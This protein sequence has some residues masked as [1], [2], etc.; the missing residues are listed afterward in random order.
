MIK[1]CECGRNPITEP[2]I[3][4]YAQAIHND[5]SPICTCCKECEYECVIS[6]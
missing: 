1:M 4:P 5:N 6:I 2:H 3:C